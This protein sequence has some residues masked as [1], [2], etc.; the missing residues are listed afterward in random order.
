MCSQ[1]PRDE[2]KQPA[3]GLPPGWTYVTGEA[4]DDGRNGVPGLLIMS[5]EG[6]HQ[7]SS[8][9][10]AL[11][12]CNILGPAAEEADLEFQA[13]IGGNTK[14]NDKNHYLYGKKHYQEWIDIHGK[15]C[16]LHGVITEC[17]RDKIDTSFLSFSV[18]YNEQSRNHLLH[19]IS[20]RAFKRSRVPQTQKQNELWA[21]GGHLAY[22]AK[23]KPA[24]S[25]VLLPLKIPAKQWIVPDSQYTY[26]TK[27]PDDKILPCLVL[28]Y[29]GFRLCFKVAPS[30]IPDAGFGVFVQVD[31]MFGDQEELV[32]KAGELLDLGIYAPFRPEDLKEESVFLLK[33]FVHN[34]KCEEWSFDLTEPGFQ[35]DIT[36]DED[37][38]LHRDAAH[39]VPAYVNECAIGQCPTVHAEHDPEGVVHYLFGIHKADLVLPCEGAMEI[40]INY[41]KVYEPVRV[42]KGY[43]FEHR[44]NRPKPKSFAD[45]AAE[46]F[47]EV[48]RFSPHDIVKCIEFFGGVA[49]SFQKND[50][51]LGR[52][53]AMTLLLYSCALT[54]QTDLNPSPFADAFRNHTENC[55]G[56]IFDLVERIGDAALSRLLGALEFDGLLSTVVRPFLENLPKH[57]VDRILSTFRFQSDE[58]SVYENDDDENDDAKSVASDDG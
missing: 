52:A 25:T 22:L 39:H 33:N 48:G 50:G 36:N 40:Y 54:I 58:D 41:G 21:R 46:Y 7:F 5:P 4:L 45:E 51:T 6:D 30:S 18:S 11:K 44:S 2:R 27:T 12:H 55:L 35:Y 3:P 24:S 57:Q 34:L 19:A 32:L 53:L 10:V 8:C 23:M 14:W 47:E 42:R 13:H 15:K 28:Q 31:S 26:H 29:K 17:L 20:A 37:G 43:S 49:K 56:L 38:E 9:S 1:I 16:C